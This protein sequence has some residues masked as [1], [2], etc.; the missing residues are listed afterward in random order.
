MAAAYDDGMYH[1]DQVHPTTTTTSST[2]TAKGTTYVSISSSV[3]PEIYKTSEYS[4]VSTTAYA[5]PSQSTY[6]GYWSQNAT[7]TYKSS[8]TT[9]PAKPGN[10]S[11]T[12]TTA[13]RM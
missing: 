1:P 8:N 13:D 5:P 11:K 3:T 7:V 6:V 12:A 10:F 4:Q 2:T 9:A